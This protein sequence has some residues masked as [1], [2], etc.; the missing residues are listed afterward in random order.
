M[1]QSRLSEAVKS[2]GVEVDDNTQGDLST[3]IE[4]HHAK[5]ATEHAPGSF[6]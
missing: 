5:V 3:S 1:L 6:V 4:L 2:S